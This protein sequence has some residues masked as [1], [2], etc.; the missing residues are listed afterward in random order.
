MPERTSVSAEEQDM[1]MPKCRVP[2]RLAVNDHPLL[3]QAAAAASDLKRGESTRFQG[4]VLWRSRH[5][6]PH[7]DR[8]GDRTSSTP[9]DSIYVVNAAFEQGWGGGGG[10]HLA[11]LGGRFGTKA[12]L[13]LFLGRKFQK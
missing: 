2:E 1:R 8:T 4:M 12:I 13:T 7:G 5:Y 6:H 11:Q 9:Q 3:L 10:Q